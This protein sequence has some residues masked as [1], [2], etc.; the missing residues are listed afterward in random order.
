MNRATSALDRVVVTLIALALLLGG[1][2]T[3]AWSQ[4]WL[5]DGWWSPRAF[6]LGPVPWLDEPWWPAALLVGGALLTVL[7][8]VWLVRHFR[9][10]GVQA[11]SLVGDPHGG[12]LVVEGDALASGAAASLEEASDDVTRARGKVTERGGRAVVDLTASVRRD[13]DL[14]A[15]GA[16]CDRVADDVVRSTGRSDVACRVRL[17]VAP[18]AGRA[19]RVH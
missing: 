2:W 3:V 15:V 5:P 7:G 14:A 12:S 17:K 6:L 9:S 18:R 4:G 11:L 19:P 8:L 16:L 10:H 13:A 1:A